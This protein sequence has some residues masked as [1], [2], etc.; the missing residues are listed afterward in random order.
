MVRHGTPG[1]PRVRR[2]EA[3]RPRSA[4]ALPGR[5]LLAFLTP[6]QGRISSSPLVEA[7]RVGAAD[8]V[9]LRGLADGRYVVGLDHW[10]VGAIESAPFDL[11]DGEIHTVGIEMASLDA[12]GKTPGG[13]VRISLDGRMVMDRRDRALCRATGRGCR[14]GQTPWECP[15]ARALS[16]A[17]SYWSARTRPRRTCFPGT[18][19]GRA[20]TP[21]S[22]GPCPRGESGAACR[23]RS[24]TAP[25]HSWRGPARGPRGRS[26]A[27]R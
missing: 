1:G 26:G 2:R 5:I 24:P 22:A 16:R 21:A 11:A 4:P 8:S 10:S 15:Q 13:A 27:S 12:D 6:R 25:P 14:S 23:R 20:A 9:Y 17:T 18:G 19:S 7:G 3:R